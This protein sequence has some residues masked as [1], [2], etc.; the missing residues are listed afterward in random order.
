VI[1]APDYAYGGGGNYERVLQLSFP[2]GK[3]FRLSDVDLES[4]ELNSDVRKF[5]IFLYE[6]LQPKRE[7]GV[8]NVLIITVLSLAA[9]LAA[10]RFISFMRLRRY[11]RTT[12]RI[13]E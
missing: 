8:Y 13:T 5:R 7:E 9:L 1:Y 11:L 6:P 3:R 4:L 12:H 10:I 2:D